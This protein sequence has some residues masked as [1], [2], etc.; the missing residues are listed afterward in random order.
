MSSNGYF[1]RLLKEASTFPWINSAVQEELD[2]ALKWGAVG[3]TMNPSHPPKAIRVD[4]ELW[5]PIID[6]IL[7]SNPGFSDD[8]AVDL[9]TQRIAERSSKMWLPLYKESAGKYGYVAI[10]SD[11]NTNDDASVLVRHATSYCRIGPNVVPKIPSTKTGAQAVEELAAK[12]I[13][14]ICTMGFSVAQNIAMAEA[15]ES[16]LKHLERGK[17]LPRCFVVI[18]PGILDE[19][20]SEQVELL[21]IFDVTTEILR[22]AGNAV[23]RHSYRVFKERGY[24]ADLLVGGTREKHHITDVV[25][26]KVHITHSFGTWAELQKENPPIISTISQKD[27]PEAISELEDKFE[28]FRR[29]YEIDGLKPD[30]FRSFGPCVRFNN[31]VRRG[32]AQ[33]KAEIQARRQT[34]L[35]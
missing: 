4:R 7:Q 5:G 11:P 10:Q 20:L 6:E 9:V 2:T 30:E 26:A 8:D 22:L 23:V 16:G 35:E 24:R 19:Y 18:I 13:N 34:L 15:Y 25:G 29:A 31:V 17:Q 14:T 32:Y 1:H 3:N 28:D 21:E 33:S 27:P 12:G